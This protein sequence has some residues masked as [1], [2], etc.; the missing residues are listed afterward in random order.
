MEITKK[1]LDYK[2]EILDDTLL[3]SFSLSMGELVS[4]LILLIIFY[5]EL[6]HDHQVNVG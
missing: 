2:L 3:K 1:I 6:S 4:L 5:Q